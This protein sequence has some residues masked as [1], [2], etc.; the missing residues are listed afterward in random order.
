[1]VDGFVAVFEVFV[2]VSDDELGLRKA[3][4][5]WDGFGRIFVLWAMADDI[6]VHQRRHLPGAKVV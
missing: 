2:A 1:M 5:I 6:T 3:M 4:T